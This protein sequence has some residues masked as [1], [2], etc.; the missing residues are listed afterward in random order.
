[1]RELDAV[2]RKRIST[3]VAPFSRVT[4]QHQPIESRALNRF[5]VNTTHVLRR[6]TSETGLARG[7]RNEGE[8]DSL[9]HETNEGRHKADLC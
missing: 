2:T 1:M 3:I 4:A 8:G 5:G 9:I 7:R 6:L